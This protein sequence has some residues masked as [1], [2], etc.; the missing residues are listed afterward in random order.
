MYPHR[1]R[2]RGPWD[3]TVAGGEPRQLTFPATW[4]KA[5]LPELSGR[6]QFLRRFGF[7]GRIDAHERVWLIGEG[8]EGPA[9]ISLQGER[10]GTVE[11]GKFA[12]E[13]T[14]RLNERNML[15]VDLDVSPER[16]QLWDDIAMEVRAT[17]YLS[18]VVREAGIIRGV[19]A[20][21]ADRALEVYAV[22]N[23]RTHGYCE[24]HAGSEFTLDVASAKGPVRVEL[25]NVST[26]WDVVEL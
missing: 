19:V 15:Q 18:N 5:G 17:A 20:G 13:I 7:P 11:L 25:V 8:V 26:V 21:S 4:P 2:L 10:L 23:G 12:F 6:V 9:D 24:V 14:A 3:L 16:V 1:I 22:A